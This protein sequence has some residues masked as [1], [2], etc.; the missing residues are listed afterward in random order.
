MCLAAKNAR[1]SGVP[2]KWGLKSHVHGSSSRK[3]GD[4]ASVALHAVNSWQLLTHFVMIDTARK[5]VC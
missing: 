2:P 4:S 3:R 1:N 5:N